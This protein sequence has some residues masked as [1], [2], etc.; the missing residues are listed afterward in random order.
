MWYWYVLGAALLALLTLLGLAVYVM[1]RACRR[2]PS[3]VLVS[4][5]DAKSMARYAYREELYS[6]AA[7][8]ARQPMEDI[9]IRSRDG[10]R[11]HGRLLSADKPRGVIL[12]F[13][14]YHSFAE[15]DFGCIAPLLLQEGYSLLFAD[16]RAHENSE[17]EV[18]TYGVKERYDCLEWAET[19]HARTGGRLPLYLYGLSM[20]AATVLMAGGLVL[21]DTLK[22]IVA[23]C[24][25]TTPAAQ[26]RYTLRH[27]H[28]LPGAPLLPLMDLVARAA[29]GFS[30]WGASTVKALRR[31]RVPVLLF[32]GRRDAI[33][34]Y[35]MSVENDAAAVADHA[36]VSMDEAAHCT[37]FFHDRERYMQAMLAFL[38]AHA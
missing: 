38:A 8:L 19:M 3:G 26:M 16:Q 6:G 23:D 33:V 28:H 11:L 9:T 2:A 14:G 21:P 1:G 10:L 30:I 37:C 31:S 34:P 27:K 5:E 17:G 35:S 12:A 29:K 13:H 7:W 36:F 24:G 15:K 25:F 4:D 20:G 22:G 18:V 32:H